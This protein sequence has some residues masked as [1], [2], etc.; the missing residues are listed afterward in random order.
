M[1]Q[2]DLS[3]ARADVWPLVGEVADQFGTV[4]EVYRGALVWLNQD[5]SNVQ[6]GE[7]QGVFMLLRSNMKDT[8]RAPLHGVMPGEKKR[9]VA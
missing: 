9:F 1:A 7:A 2:T 4:D 5:V 6:P 3:A 8:H